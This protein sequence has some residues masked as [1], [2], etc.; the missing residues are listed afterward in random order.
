MKALLSAAAISLS[1]FAV[2]TSVWAA[3][4]GSKDEAVAMVKKAVALL[5]CNLFIPLYRRS[6]QAF[7]PLFQAFRT[8]FRFHCREAS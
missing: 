3:D 1:L 2:S 7:G 6:W 4:K 8:T 5:F